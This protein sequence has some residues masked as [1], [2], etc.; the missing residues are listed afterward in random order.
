MDFSESLFFNPIAAARMCGNL[1][2]SGSTRLETGAKAWQHEPEIQ[3]FESG[4]VLAAAFWYPLSRPKDPELGSPFEIRIRKAGQ[5]DD[6]ATRKI[7]ILI[8]ESL[9][10]DVAGCPLNDSTGTPAQPGMEDVSLEE[11]YWIRLKSGESYQTAT[12]GDFAILVG[13]HLVHK[14]E[15][16]GWLWS[17]FWW[18]D[19]RSEPF[20]SAPAT[21]TG[22]GDY[23]DAWL[24]YAMDAAFG[25]PG[26]VIYNPWR[27][28][29][30]ANRNCAACHQKLA[31]IGESPQSTLTFD[32]VITARVHF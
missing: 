27:D 5:K 19:S 25:D 7:R 18:D 24:N 29:E 23:P 10:N 20:G 11:F 26:K 9:R 30:V 4:S 16:K 3:P 15:A 1:D 22:A 8:P 6:I 21:F 12:C 32:M 13:F 2:A 17:T 31:T 14:V 28:S